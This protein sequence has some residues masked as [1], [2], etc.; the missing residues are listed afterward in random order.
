MRLGL[1]SERPLFIGFGEPT[2]PI[3]GQGILLFCWNV[4]ERA[5]FYGTRL[6]EGALRLLG[7]DF[8]F[9]K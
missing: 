9:T 7:R 4:P 3:H 8:W 6:R 1:F 5:L 2:I